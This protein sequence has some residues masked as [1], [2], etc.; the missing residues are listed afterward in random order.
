M[1]QNIYLLYVVKEMKYLKIK[2]IK[3]NKYINRI[4]PRRIDPYED[5]GINLVR[6]NG[7]ELLLK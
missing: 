5:D 2:F 3:K 7:I 6:I 4:L 1:K